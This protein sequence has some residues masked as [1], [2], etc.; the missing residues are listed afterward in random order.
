MFIDIDSG[1]WWKCFLDFL[2]IFLICK[3]YLD[4]IVCE[5]VVYNECGYFNRVKFDS[6]Y[7]ILCWYEVYCRNKNLKMFS[8]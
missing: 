2:V 3:K 7:V 6:L 4:N 1:M 5:E 8:W